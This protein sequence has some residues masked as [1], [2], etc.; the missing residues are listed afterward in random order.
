MDARSSVS[1]A[2]VQVAHSIHCPTRCCTSKV[3]RASPLLRVN[4]KT[5]A[6]RSARKGGTDA[7]SGGHDIARFSQAT[8]AN[9]KI[10]LNFQIAFITPASAVDC[11]R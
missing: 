10:L 1:I 9:F 5:A 7:G 11:V 2:L 6:R 4:R 3:L 8:E